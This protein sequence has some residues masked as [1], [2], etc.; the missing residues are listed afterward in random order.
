MLQWAF[1]IKCTIQSICSY[2]KNSV[3]K[4][5]TVQEEKTSIEE[6]SFRDFLRSYFS[7]THL[8]SV[9]VCQ[10]ELAHALI[11]FRYRASNCVVMHKPIS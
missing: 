2:D 3:N 7:D 10:T 8:V 6:D 1:K 9:L 11:Q 4:V 5:P